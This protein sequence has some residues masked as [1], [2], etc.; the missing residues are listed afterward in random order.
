MSI[1]VRSMT[2]DINEDTTT[3]DIP[4]DLRREF[5]NQLAGRVYMP[6]IVETMVNSMSTETAISRLVEIIVSSNLST[7]FT[8]STDTTTPDTTTPDTSAPK[9][10]EFTY[11]GIRSSS[12]P[13]LV[14]NVRINPIGIADACSCEGFVNHQHCKHVSFYNIARGRV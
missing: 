4:E 1:T 5:V 12:R 2:F 6:E 13:N 7:E 14:H 11:V 8:L 3:D 9:E 10:S